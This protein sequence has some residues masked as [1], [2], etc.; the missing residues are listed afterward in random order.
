[1]P[2]QRQAEI[3]R[4][5][6]DSYIDSANPVSSGEL[7]YSNDLGVSSATVRHELAELSEEGLLFRPHKSS[8]VV[9][10]EQ[11]YRYYVES[12]L[13]NVDLPL[14]QKDMIRHQFHQVE[15]DEDRWI[16]LAASILSRRLESLAVVTP[17]YHKDVRVKNVDIVKISEYRA[18]L[19]QILEGGRV[20]RALI[21]LPGGIVWSNLKEFVD[22]LSTRYSGKTYSDI[23]IAYRGL[24]DPAQKQILESSINLL[25][26]ARE[27]YDGE[28]FVYGF[29]E[30]LNQPEFYVGGEL[31]HDLL[32]A[33]E[34]GMLVEALHPIDMSFGELRVVIGHEHSETFLHPYGVVL[35][36]YGNTSD[37]HGTVA[38]IGPTRMS[39]A[40]AIPSVR[41]MA[42]VLDELTMELL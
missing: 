16:R 33:V 39:Y 20:Q 28:P 37:S 6:V 5:L 1:M 40:N 42:D 29:T 36:T 19:V 22:I 7:V 26:Q 12:L 31:I 2:T 11:G 38:V 34:K 13:Q 15:L 17:V 32:E 10:T 3:L 14:N 21:Q 30:V 23:E 27:Q 18:M 4:L 8:G 41:F 24:S 25:K 9:P 35:T